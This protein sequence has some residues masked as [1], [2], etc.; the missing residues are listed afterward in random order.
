MTVA[1]A[2]KL[3]NGSEEFGPLVQVTMFRLRSLLDKGM[4]VVF[5]ELVC[6]CRDRDHDPWG[7]TGQELQALK[8]VEH[9]GDRYRVHE[10]I[11]NVVLSAAEGEGLDMSIVDPVKRA[12]T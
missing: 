6:L 12:T 5:Y 1:E 3:K 4:G 11:K 7:Q 10:S 8:L 9:D 2:V